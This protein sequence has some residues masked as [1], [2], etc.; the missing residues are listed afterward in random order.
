LAALNLKGRAREIRSDN[1]N[2][3][4]LGSKCSI[5]TCCKVEHYNVLCIVKA[6]LLKESIVQG[7]STL[8]HIHVIVS[9]KNKKDWKNTF[10]PICLESFKFFLEKM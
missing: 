2:I 10:N 5:V 4:S 1:V 7:Y 8:N 6:Y 9:Y 3:R